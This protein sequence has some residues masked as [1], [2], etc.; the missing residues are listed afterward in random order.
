MTQSKMNTNM[1]AL[2]FGREMRLLLIA[3]AAGLLLCSDGAAQSQTENYSQEADKGPEAVAA[4][5]S[6]EAA[7][8]LNGSDRAKDAPMSIL[9]RLSKE[10]GVSQGWDPK[11]NRWS[12]VVEFKYP[13]KQASGKNFANAI[14]ARD[15][16][17][18]GAFLKAQ[19]ALA[20]WY[21]AN[22]SVE[23]ALSNPGDPLVSSNQALADSAK[24]RAATVQKQLTELMTD[25]SEAERQ[26]LGSLLSARFSAAAQRLLERIAPNASVDAETR[27]QR[28]ELVAALKAQISEYNRELRELE[29]LH[30]NYHA[31]F[32]KK[33][34][35][36]GTRV[37]FDH[38]F[39]GLSAVAMAE[40]VTETQ[41]EVAVLY[42]WS[43]KV[44]QAAVRAM[45]GEG[46]EP[47]RGEVG[48]LSYE[49][50]RA[51]QNMLLMP[52]VGNYL[53]NEGNYWFYGVGIA[54]NGEDAAEISLQ[55][56]MGAVLLSLNSSLAGR[57]MLS[58]QLRSGEIGNDYVQK[59]S[60]ELLSR[61]DANTQGLSSF[62]EPVDFPV[63]Q[64]GEVTTVPVYGT[65]SAMMAGSRS[66][67]NKAL[68][69]T[70]LDAARIARDNNRRS[71]EVAQASASVKQAQREM[72]APA[73]AKQDAA[74]KTPP[75]TK[76]TNSA[77]PEMQPGTR[78][79]PVQKPNFE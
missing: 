57:V 28:E 27:R 6:P 74:P 30:K 37:E 47:K 22:A 21:G 5:T 18:V 67:A 1:N 24:A 17:F 3:S 31:N 70:K 79:S 16:A 8:K 59:F 34:T 65:I 58:Q 32:A 44:A 77:E 55:R 69:Q 2:R 29:D 54:A 23:V 19:A 49:D 75:A 45:T 53:D 15:V 52:P 73:K 64:G 42:I 78:V 43:P 51:K 61:T 60:Q 56:A 11:N 72:S 33:T 10:A 68:L 36:T 25:L 14:G 38:H 76:K 50:W 48:E 41:H 13:L 7:Q 46:S 20:I 62:T 35:T 40:R 12:A 66:A 9:N 71:F 39:V 26:S 4:L 63:V